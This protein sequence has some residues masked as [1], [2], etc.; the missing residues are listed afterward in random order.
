MN[1]KLTSEKMPAFLQE[2]LRSEDHIVAFALFGKFEFMA[3]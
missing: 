1:E 2:F 3:L